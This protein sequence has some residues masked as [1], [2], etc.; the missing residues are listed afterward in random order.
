MTLPKTAVKSA[1]MESERFQRLVDV[2]HRLRQECPWDRE[3]TSRSILPYLVEET[4]EVIEAIER[5]EPAA[6]RAELGDLLLQ[7]L[8]HSEMA[9]ERGDFDVYDVADGVR[10]KMIRRHPHVFADADARSADAVLG[11]WSRIKREERRAE[12][13]ST[14][15]LAGVPRALPALLR[16]QRLGDKA[17]RVGFDWPTP[18]DVLTK[19]REELDELEQALE[20]GDPEAVDHE[21]GD[22]LFALTSF[23]RKARVDAEFALHRALDRFRERFRHMERSLES[24]GRDVHDTSREDLEAEWENAKKRLVAR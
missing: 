18:R 9:S 3:Q 19:V 10:E 13:E 21:I 4:Y 24:A 16:A 7:V 17:S 5:G 6:I 1:R 14:S 20:S 23:A 22:C 11:N 8:F 12:G 2:M 15:V